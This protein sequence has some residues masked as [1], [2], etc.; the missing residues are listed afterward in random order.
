M[1]KPHVIFTSK[2]LGKKARALISK[3]SRLPAQGVDVYGGPV[4]PG[5]AGYGWT[6][7]RYPLRR[8]PTKVPP[9]WA[10]VEIDPALSGNIGSLSPSDLAFLNGLKGTGVVL[11]PS[12]DP[13]VYEP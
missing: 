1:P 4:G 7:Y 8:H 12:W 5:T 2:A 6:L 10:H 9:E 13:A 11:D 3:L